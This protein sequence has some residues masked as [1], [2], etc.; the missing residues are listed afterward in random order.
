MSKVGKTGLRMS[1]G[2]LRNFK[3]ERKRDEYERVAKAVKHGFKPT[4]KKAKRR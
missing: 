1:S 4:G 3:S 2:K